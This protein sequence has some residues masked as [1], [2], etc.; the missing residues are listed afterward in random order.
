MLIFFEG[1]DKSG[2][3]T[4]AKELVKFLQSCGNNAVYLKDYAS[5]EVIKHND[6]FPYC[7]YLSLLGS[8]FFEHLD[9][10]KFIIFDRYV[11]SDMVYS[12]VFNRK[13][14]DA[15]NQQVLDTIKKAGGMHVICYKT[16]ELQ[17]DEIFSKQDQI[18]DEYLKIKDTNIL[19][20]DTTSENLDDELNSIFMKMNELS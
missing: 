10:N 13:T 1:H 8:L 12:K 5:Y 2:K 11:L 7:S 15:I 6:E 9:P 4:I 3:T 14:D 16:N 17:N 18:R 19:H 20:L